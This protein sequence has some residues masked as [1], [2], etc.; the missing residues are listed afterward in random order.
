MSQ[1]SEIGSFTQEIESELKDNI[2][3]FW[4][5]HSTDDENGGFYGF[6][7][8]ELSID[9]THEK[10]SVLNFRILW[11]FSTAYR[12]V[13]NVI[14]FGHDIEGSWLLYEAAE[15]LGDAQLLKKSPRNI[16]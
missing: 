11:T 9:K 1:N 16:C 12:V 3:Q 2:L 15:V 14:S 13:S 8:D 7:S 6:I 10:S 4:I 5:D